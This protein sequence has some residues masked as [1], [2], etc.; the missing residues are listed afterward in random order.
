MP[1]GLWKGVT[2]QNQTLGGGFRNPKAVNLSIWQG[3][4]TRFVEF[5]CTA[6]I[7]SQFHMQFRIIRWMYNLLLI[8][9]VLKSPVDLLEIK[10]T[11]LPGL[12]D[13]AYM[14][15]MAL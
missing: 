9:G 10:K 15:C 4:P 7:S 11:L 13:L 5:V 3:L 2:A 12:L 1:R 8:H 14:F 6:T